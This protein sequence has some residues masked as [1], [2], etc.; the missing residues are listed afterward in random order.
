MNRIWQGWGHRNV[1]A[2]RVGVSHRKEGYSN[3]YSCQITNKN[4]RHEKRETPPPPQLICIIYN[5]WSKWN[6]CCKTNNL[7]TL[8]MKVNILL[9]LSRNEVWNL[10]GSSTSVCPMLYYGYLYFLFQ[11]C[12]FDGGWWNVATRGIPNLYYNFA[13]KPDV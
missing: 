8:R 13:I 2:Q 11:L 4:E 3:F 9:I 5:C 10:C 6:Y 12:I 1:A 7:A